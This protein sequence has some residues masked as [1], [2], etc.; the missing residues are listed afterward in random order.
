M[1]IR[2]RI[3]VV[4][5]VVCLLASALAGA[6]RAATGGFVVSSGAFRGNGGLPAAFELNTRSGVR[7]W[8]PLRVGFNL[9][10]TFASQYDLR[11]PAQGTRTDGTRIPLEYHLKNASV[12]VFPLYAHL[13]A[14]RSRGL[15]VTAIGIGGG[16]PLAFLEA[17]GF[18][19][20]IFGGWGGT[21]WAGEYVDLRPDN[22]VNFIGVGIEA[23]YHV[24]KVRRDTFD[25]AL[26]IPVRQ[27]LDTAGGSVRFA[28]RMA[29][30][31]APATAATA[32]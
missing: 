7:V 22:P 21:V 4:A 10:G 23:A 19:T 5:I 8:G 29:W 13:Y 14:E 18:K 2:V 12:D 31:E 16:Y 25:R 9:G 1:T 6:A 15:T 26:A 32:R 11:I 30:R 20:E 28:I 17:D 24:G 3:A 27:E